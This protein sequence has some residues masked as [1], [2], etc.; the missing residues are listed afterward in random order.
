LLTVRHITT[1]CAVWP[2][3]CDEP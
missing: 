2:S 3:C 1:R